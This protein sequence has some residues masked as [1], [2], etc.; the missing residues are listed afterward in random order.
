MTGTATGADVAIARKA[1]KRPASAA[2]PGDTL[3]SHI[4]RS[5]SSR[6][7]ELIAPNSRWASSGAVSC[8]PG[9]PG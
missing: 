5:A 7:P 3:I 8:A 2:K 4:A 1:S 6:S 9:P